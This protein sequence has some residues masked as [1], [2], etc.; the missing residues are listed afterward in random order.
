MIYQ[1]SLNGAIGASVNA[2]SNIFS[3][4]ARASWRTLLLKYGPKANSC[5]TCSVAHVVKGTKFKR[6]FRIFQKS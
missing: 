3:L 6:I 4:E 2:I 1:V 5:N